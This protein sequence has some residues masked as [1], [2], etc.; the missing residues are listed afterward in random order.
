MVN[1]NNDPFARGD[2]ATLG[3]YGRLLWRDKWLFLAITIACTVLA[4]VASFVVQKTYEAAIILSPISNNSSGMGGGMA[5]A[6]SQFGGLA[7]LAGIGLG[8]DS[9][10]S[11]SIAVLQSEAL[12]ESYIQR[13]NL[14][15]VL[16]SKFWDPKSASWTVKDPEKMPTLWKANK[17]FEK[18]IR[19]VS[20]NAKTGLVTLM[21]TW[22]DP[23]TA[24][25]W[26]NDIAKMT[27]DYLRDKA[28][29][30]SE[31]N[32]KYLTDEATKTN[33]V[34][35]RQAIFSILQNELDK[36]MVARGNEEFA[37]KI[38]DP[39]VPPERPASPQKIFWLAGGLVGGAILSSLIIL[40][41]RNRKHPTI[42]PPRAG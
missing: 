30:E 36:A 11:E 18:R 41:V 42:S 23:K 3:D 17:L 9:K 1:S 8:N 19:S 37:F 25:K 22:T 39:A 27:N 5:S 29:K 35:A 32:I 7:A 26:A 12:T 28:I 14:L 10:K 24:A 31:R 38:I 2:D 40:F 33:I 34:E 20:L 13:E 6:M 16:Y 15:P 21:I 4:T